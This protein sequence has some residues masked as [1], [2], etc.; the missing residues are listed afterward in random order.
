VLRQL[1]QLPAWAQIEN[2]GCVLRIASLAE[3]AEHALQQVRCQD[4][5]QDAQAAAQKLRLPMEFFACQVDLHGGVVRLDFSAPERVDFNCL[6]RSLSP[7]YGKTF[8]WLRQSK[9][10]AL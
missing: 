3:I 9:A 8:F 2:C 1:P 7:K 10:S 4:I 5:L 6:T